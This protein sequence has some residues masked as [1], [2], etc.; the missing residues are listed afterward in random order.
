MHLVQDAAQPDHVR[1]DAHPLPLNKASGLTIEVWAKENF[2]S[3]EDLKAFV[4]EDKIIFPNIAQ[5]LNINIG[6]FL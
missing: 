6:F 3:I 2:K 5:P 4:P 1:N